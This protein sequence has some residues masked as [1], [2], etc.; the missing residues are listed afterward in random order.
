MEQKTLVDNRMKDEFEDINTKM[1][2]KTKAVKS[3]PSIFV[4]EKALFHLLITTINLRSKDA[5]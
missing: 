2:C 1:L 4:S 3:S 5:Q